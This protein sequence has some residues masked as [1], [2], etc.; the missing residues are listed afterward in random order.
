MGRQGLDPNRKCHTVPKAATLLRQRTAPTMFRWV[1]GH[2]GNLGNEESDRLAKEGAR[3][4]HQDLIDLQNTNEFHPQGA[5]LQ[6]MTQATAYQGIR[7][8]KTSKEPPVAAELI[9]E[10]REEINNYTGE[11]ETNGTIWMS[12]RKPV[13]RTRVQQFLYKTIHQAHMIGDVWSHIPGFGQRQ[14]CTV[15]DETDSIEHILVH[16]QANTR[17][18]IWDLAEQQWPHAQEQWPRISPGLI[19]GIGCINVPRPRIKTAPHPQHQNPPIRTR[20]ASRLLQILISE[21]SHLV[22]VLRCE[23]VIQDKQHTDSE[24]KARW[25]RAINERLTCDRISA[26]KIKRNDAFTNLIKNTWGPL[27]KK[28]RTIPDDWLNR[29]EVLVGSGRAY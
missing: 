13:L 12:L 15:C 23:R 14:F 5:K 22:W 7:M 24:I 26:T 27:L 17:R 4:N 10:V 20:G 28:H 9:N 25:L 29:S 8:I 3:K 1:K 2:Q 6:A 18:I 11:Y 16:C 21:A 19:L